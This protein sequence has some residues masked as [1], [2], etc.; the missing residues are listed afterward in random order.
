[1]EISY[2]A[3]KRQ[4]TLNARGLDFDDAPE[5]FSGFHLT[6][7]D[8]RF[9]YGEDREI[10]V[11]ALKGKIVVIVWVDREDGRRIISMREAS[12]DEQRYYY[13]ELDRSG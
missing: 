3:A 5:V 12:R 10:T 2:D 9:E 8:L 1:M 13:R 6:D 11:G 7:Q 4:Q